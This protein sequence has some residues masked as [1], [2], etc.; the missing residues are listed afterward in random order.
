MAL[1]P[2][3]VIAQVSGRSAGKLGA[4][5]WEWIMRADGQVFYRLTDVNGRRERNPWILATRR[6][7]WPPSAGTRL[8][9]PRCWTSSSASTDTVMSQAPV[10]KIDDRHLPQEVMSTVHSARTAS[11]CSPVRAGMTLSH[12]C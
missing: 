12:R 11:I 9:P 2:P 4:M 8:R 1:L 6:P 3:K 10:E 7:N 5:S